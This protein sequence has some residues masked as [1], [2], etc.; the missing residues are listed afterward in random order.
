MF[1]PQ[2]YIAANITW[3]MQPSQRDL[4]AA[5]TT[6]IPFHT[7]VSASNPLQLLGV[8]VR[9]TT[10]TYSVLQLEPISTEAWSQR[11]RRALPVDS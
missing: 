5:S 4:N 9:V 2:A 8:G 6:S 11:A 3:Q 7:S 1:G 10:G